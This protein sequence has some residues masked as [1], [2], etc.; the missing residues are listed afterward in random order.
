MRNAFRKG[1]DE[2]TKEKYR[3][4]ASVEVIQQLARPTKASKLEGPLGENWS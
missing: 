2:L 4:C 1:T 3:F